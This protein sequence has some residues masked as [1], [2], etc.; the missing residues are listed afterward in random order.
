MD[1]PASQPITGTG[2][3]HARRRSKAATLI[4][5]LV[6]LL[7]M[8]LFQTVSS[9]WALRKYPPVGNLIDVGGYALH[10]YAEGEA[11]GLPTVVLESGLG[12]P[13]SYSDWK[14]VIAELSKLT[15]VVTYDRAGYGWSDEANNERS[16]AQEAEELHRLLAASGEPGPYIVVGHSYGGYIAQLFANR[17]P[18]ETAGMVLIDS[19][20]AG[21]NPDVSEGGLNAQKMM[22]QFGLMRLLGGLGVLPIPEAI[23]ADPLSES[24]LYR[25]FNNDDQISELLL[26]G[27]VSTEQVQ[28][29]ARTGFG[30]MPV[31]VLSSGEEQNNHGNWYEKQ[32]ELLQL[33][34]RSKHIIAEHSSHFIHHDR[35]ELVI[36]EIRALLTEGSGERETQIK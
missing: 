15:R 20:I 26:L 32:A 31:T 12:T 13:S 19:S 6:I 33:S 36:G 10:L 25:R 17:Y 34:S 23:M 30:S 22:R 11:K 28:A 8:P 1:M 24:F 5:L 7:G 2:K 16:S 21:L 27:T 4:A 18:H 35:P 29:V 9:E 3:A 14:H